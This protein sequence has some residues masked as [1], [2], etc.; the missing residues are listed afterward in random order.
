MHIYM[1]QYSNIYLRIYINF[2]MA[3]GAIISIYVHIWRW[4]SRGNCFLVSSQNIYRALLYS[5]G[6]LYRALFADCAY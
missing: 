4:S 3:A 5:F 2:E 1:F 6:R